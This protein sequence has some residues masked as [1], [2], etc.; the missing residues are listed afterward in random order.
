[1]I[2]S[3]I[4]KT[5]LRRRRSSSCP[6]VRPSRRPFFR[7]PSSSVVRPSSVT[8][9]VRRPSRRAVVRRPS[10][11]PRSSFFEDIGFV[12]PRAVGD[13]AKRAAK[14]AAK[15]LPGRSGA[16]TTAKH[17]AQHDGADWFR[18]VRRYAARIGAPLYNRF[19]CK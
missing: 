7:R 3:F 9:S 16:A 17:V 18:F 8:S 4:Q 13:T 15:G 19:L 14:R 5:S 1:M 6:P 10:R 12:A 2:H 11:R